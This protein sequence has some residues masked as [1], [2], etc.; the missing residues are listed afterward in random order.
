MKLLIAILQDRD[1]GAVMERLIAEGYRV[2]RIASTGGFLRRG[3]I[4]LLIGAEAEEVDGVINLLRQA[5]APPEP[6]QHRATVFVVDAAHF[7]Q[8]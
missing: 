3:N 6:G 5:C 7:E 8:I 4:T 2:T 1:A